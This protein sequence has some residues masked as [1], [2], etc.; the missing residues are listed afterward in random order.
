MALRQTVTSASGVFFSTVFRLSWYDDGKRN[1]GIRRVGIVRE[2]KMEYIGIRRANKD[3]YEE[4]Q[5]FYYSLIDSLKPE[6]CYVGWKKGIYPS[7]EFIRSSIENGD[8]YFCRDGERIAGAMVLNHEYNES[9]KSYQWHTNV[10]DSEL[11]IIHALGVHSDFNGKGYA[12]A[13]VQK[14]IDIAKETG[15]KA[16]RLDVLRGNIPAEKLYQRFG[17]QY[18]ATLQMYY[19]DTGW[20]DFKLYEYVL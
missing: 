14:A 19:E 8:L 3:I 16:I 7:Q 5:L 15:M 2:N 13:M 17:F 12:K 4:M 9:Y 10:D 11:L 6:Q 20:T 1:Q 18:M